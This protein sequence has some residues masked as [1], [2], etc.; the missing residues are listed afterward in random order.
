MADF[1]KGLSGGFQTGLQLGQA[2]RERRQRD[3]LAKEAARYGVTEGAYGPELLQNIEQLEGLKARDPSQAAAYDQAIAELERRS[4]MTAPDFSVSSGAQN[5]ATREEA[6][7][8]VRP[9]RAEGLSRVYEQF[10]DIE[11]AEELRERADAGRFR[12]VQMESA[13]IGL[14]GK[15]QEETAR[16]NLAAFDAE[17]RPD[18]RPDEIKALAEKHNLTRA[19]HL[20]VIEQMAG[21]QEGELK[22]FDAEV[23]NLMKGKNLSGLAELYNTDERFDPN[24]GLRVSKGKD[25]KVTLEFFDVET[26]QVVERE[27]YASEALAVRDLTI[28]ATAPEQLAEWRLGIRAKEAQIGLVGAQ[29]DKARAE[30]VRERPPVSE[31][32]LVKGTDFDFFVD[33]R[34][35]P[36]GRPDPQLGI[37]PLGADPRSDERLVRSLATGGASIV[38]VQTEGG[39]P[40]W[41]YASATGEIF[42]NPD[43]AIKASRPIADTPTREGITTRERRTRGQRR[44]GPSEQE[45]TLAR[46]FDSLPEVRSMQARIDAALQAGRGAEVSRMAAELAQMRQQYIAQGLE[47]R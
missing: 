15:R 47:Q 24:T 5:F 45:V 26:N 3:A 12:Q 30:A 7:R 43:E 6:E 34:G 35:T 41:A 25:G 28:R 14:R 2:V 9:T 22:Q 29:T 44:Q 37:V 11:K 10:G 39:R 18:M 13:E 27:Q 8:A 16:N 1:F 4:K 31:F 36:V 40:M 46:Q 20:G 33:A 19:Q 42:D 17:Y 38:S 32:K 21:L 23:K